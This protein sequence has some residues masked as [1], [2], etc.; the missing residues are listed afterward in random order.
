MLLV[1]ATDYLH[2]DDFD[3]DDDDENGVGTTMNC[4]FH[5]LPR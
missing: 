1:S 3:D 4:L 5:L 2:R